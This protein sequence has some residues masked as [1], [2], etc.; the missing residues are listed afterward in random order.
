MHFNLFLISCAVLNLV[1][2]CDSAND[3][4]II[5]LSNS[6]ENVTAE[7]N[8]TEYELSSTGRFIFNKYSLRNFN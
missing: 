4:V 2:I 8:L 6:G 1:L 5:N 3:T 7:R